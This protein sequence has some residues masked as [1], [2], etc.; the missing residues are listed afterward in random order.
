[1]V[2]ATDLSIS[3]KGISIRSVVHFIIIL[4][5]IIFRGIVFQH[6]V[7][8]WGLET[9]ECLA[10]HILDDVSRCG[11]MAMVTMDKVEDN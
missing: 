2:G 9:R 3:D 11:S 5:V 4:V 8:C 7:M 6:R 1:M 10:F